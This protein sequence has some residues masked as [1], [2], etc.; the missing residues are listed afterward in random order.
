MKEKKKKKDIKEIKEIQGKAILIGDSMVG[1]TSL[2]RVATGEKFDGDKESGRTMA[3]SCTEKK[4]KIGSSNYSINLWDTIG[5]EQHR[6]INGQFYR[7]SDIVIFVYDITN[8]ATF[9]NLKY[10]FEDLK[11][12]INPESKCICGIVG[13]KK[14]LIMNQKISEKDGK[15]FA[16][17]MNMKFKQV[18]AKNDPLSFIKFLEELTK[19]AKDNL[20]EKKENISLKHQKKKFIEIFKCK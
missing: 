11:K 3:A 16:E 17:S 6:Q 19:D 14:D 7:G 13:N 9:D 10:W 2:I 15:K 5:Q 18:S 20:L 1:K 4:F 12:Y 8:Q